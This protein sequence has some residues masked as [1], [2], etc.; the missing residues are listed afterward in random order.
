MT[1]SSATG[2]AATSTLAPLAG[3]ERGYWRGLNHDGRE[4]PAGSATRA[5][6]AGGAAARFAAEFSRDRGAESV[7]AASAAPPDWRRRA[8][9]LR[10]LRCCFCVDESVSL[11]SRGIVVEQGRAAWEANGV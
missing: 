8:E 9:W 11:S 10:V 5:G 2:Q 6:G 1:G 3:V 4:K 7:G